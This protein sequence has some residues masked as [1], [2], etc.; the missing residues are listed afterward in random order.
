M[1]LLV[2]GTTVVAEPREGESLLELLREDLGLRTMKDGCSPEGSC[3]ACTVLVDGRAVVSCAQKASRAAGKEVVTQEGLSEDERRLWARAFVAAGASQ[4]GYCS[5]GIVMKA[6]GLL[7]K[8]GSGGTG[9]FA[10]LDGLDLAALAR[11]VVDGAPEA[12]AEAKLSSGMRLSVTVS[13]LSGENARV[14]GLVLV[15][16]DVT[17]ARRLQDQLAQ[18]EKLS[19]LGRMLSGVAHELNNPLTSVLGFSEMARST[20]PGEKLERRL[21]LVHEEARRC[22]KV[23]QNLLRFARRHQPERKPL[24]LNEVV[25]ST[26]A[27]LGYQLRVDGVHLGLELD[28]D[29][30]RSTE[31]STSCSRRS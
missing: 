29:L 6:E 5:P 10:R 8:V 26:A 21:T 15:C 12:C 13:P 31:T 23:V 22:Q 27:L 25:H 18:S 28:A 2:N 7:R 1:E 19:S 20:P 9:A 30:R 16:A 3:G 14:E 4:C 24:S 11:T 17:D